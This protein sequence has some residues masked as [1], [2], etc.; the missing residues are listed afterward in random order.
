MASKNF[1]SNYEHRKREKL[2]KI[3]CAEQLRQVIWHTAS[4][5]LQIFMIIA[6]FSESLM[7]FSLIMSQSKEPFPRL[8]QAL[9]AR[10]CPN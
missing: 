4:R 7:L 6:Q 3:E 5:S 9:E 2:A 1:G 10:C 8:F